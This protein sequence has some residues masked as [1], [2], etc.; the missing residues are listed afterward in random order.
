MPTNFQLDRP[1]SIAE[2]TLDQPASG[3]EFTAVKTSRSSTDH[4]QLGEEQEELEFSMSENHSMHSVVDITN[5]DTEEDTGHFRLE[6]STPISSFSGNKPD[7]PPKPPHFKLR[8]DVNKY[9]H[10]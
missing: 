1:V 8:K 4:G 6:T 7:I 9:K 3:P 10:I 2:V 5:D